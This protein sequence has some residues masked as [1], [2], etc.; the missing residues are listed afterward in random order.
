MTAQPTGP[1]VVPTW[2]AEHAVAKLAEQLATPLP[3]P[4]A[5]H[6]VAVEVPGVQRWLQQQLA[7]HLGSSG[8]DDGICAGVRMPTPRHLI[9][10]IFDLVHPGAVTAWR[11][12]EIMWALLQAFE[13]SHDEAWFHPL[14]AHLRTPGERPGRRT[15]LAHRLARLFDDYHRHR[16]DVVLAWSRGATST[17]DGLEWQP[18]LWRAVREIIGVP[19]PAELLPSVVEQMQSLSDALPWPATVHVWRPDGMDPLTRAVLDAVATSRSVRIWWPQAPA[20]D[21]PLARESRAQLS[22]LQAPL[23]ATPPEPATS[24]LGHL[25]HNLLTGDSQQCAPD[26]SVVFHASHG[27]TRQVE[28]LRDAIVGAL[29]DD[30]SIQP[31]D[32]AILC[33]SL[34]TWAPLV[35]TTFGHP[36]DDTEGHHPG[37]TLPLRIA[38]PSLR[39]VNPVLDVLRRVLELCR[40]RATPSELLELCAAGPVAHHFHFDDDDLTRIGELVRDSGM[41][42]GMD[43][44][45]RRDLG[46]TTVPHYTWRWALDRMLAGVVLP[47]TALLPLV[48]P[49]AE[50]SSSDTTLIGRLATIVDV[51]SRARLHTT[52]EHSLAE[53]ITWS[54]S[55]LS[56]LT[57]TSGGDEW[58]TDHA[59]ATL[60]DLGPRTAGP[61]MGAEDFITT[62]TE[63]FR[64][65]PPRSAFGSGAITM[66][67]PEMLRAVPHAVICLL[68]FDDD[69][70]SLPADSLL[71]REPRPE[72][73]LPRTRRRQL[74]FD[75]VC[76]AR[77]RLIVVVSGHDSRTN[78]PTP[79]PVQ[80][81]DLWRR[82]HAQTGVSPTVAHGLQPHAAIEFRSQAPLSFDA[83]ALVAAQRSR[84]PREPALQVWQQVPRPPAELTVVELPDLISFHECAVRSHLRHLGLPVWRERVD[85]EADNVPVELNALDRWAITQRFLT[86]AER[87]RDLDCLETAE[88]Q[89]GTVPPG[90]LG[91]G[92]VQR[93]RA[94]VAKTLEQATSRRS[95]E[96]QLHYVDLPLDGCT[97]TGAVTT[98]DDT[99]VDVVPRAYPSEGDQIALWIR[100][101]ALAA[102]RPDHPAQGVVIGSRHTTRLTAPSASE[103]RGRLADL[104]SIMG[105]GLT[106]PLPLVPPVAAAWARN[107]RA[108][109]D[110]WQFRKNRELWDR[111]FPD[112]RSVVEHPRFSEL[113]DLVWRPL[114]D[115]TRGSR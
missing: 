78:L 62:L 110:K 60:A 10:E 28:V 21:D 8:Q 85:P 112:A 109:A 59:W 33:P 2:S 5:D 95:G 52:T 67:T 20:H 19:G 49:L 74:L 69:H 98:H 88:W 108:A 14:R 68:G 89:R 87:G 17:P 115:A 54:R 43:V 57:S 34:E 45:H 30:P 47:T 40:G 90:A 50:I 111:F 41:R 71:L 58:Q 25:Q 102:D 80:L 103:A 107:P 31:R 113:T 96:R 91:E 70:P 36:G 92:P 11:H 66:C 65:R 9:H 23:P 84:Q 42:W 61:T 76:A 16:H 101:L 38:D 77:K 73:P 55:L 114:V 1:M 106:T 35:R 32:I 13:S 56:D 94:A 48:T 53:W 46:Y 99:I 105:Q 27:P 79:M 44:G 93:V 100:L 3:D 7:L 82:V 12:T 6:L 24:S 4:F 29:A 15:D 63:A 22:L 81:G 39:E 72:D 18:P 97:L 26:A 86:G 104:L 51:V 83:A 37:R 75:A 64:G